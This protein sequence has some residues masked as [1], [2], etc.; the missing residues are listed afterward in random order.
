LQG[1][2]LIHDFSGSTF[3]VSLVEAHGNQISVLHQA[4]V[5][6]LGERDFHHVLLRII[7]EKFQAKTGD[8]FDT[9]DCNFTRLDIESTLSTLI[10][11]PTVMI[12][13]TS[14]KHGPWPI[15]V[16]R[17]EFEAGIA[18]LVTQAE[19]ACEH[20]MRCGKDDPAQHTKP[21]EIRDVFMIGKASRVPALQASVERLFRKKPIIQEP[22]QAIANGAAIYAV[23]K[24]N[25]SLLNALQ[26][27]SLDALKVSLKAPHYFGLAF[28]DWLTG[29]TYNRTIIPKGTSLPVR[30]TFRT[31]ADA[32]GHLPTIRLT[33][34]SI[35]EKNV[36]FVTT[37]WSGNVAPTAPHADIEL[38]FAY[39]ENGT[40]CFS[41]TEVATGNTTIV[42]LRPVSD[43]R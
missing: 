34:S 29:E 13:L 9:V 23:L 25:H 32:R 17:D 27:R 5:Q 36:E 35:E 11:R 41:V 19:M 33:Q 26:L 14:G 12:R 16:S 10:L 40:M 4:S 6:Q 31:Q 39:D 42:D 21:S 28:T 8:E 15:E 18:H 30:R 22:D 1:K 37:I 20:V 7:G 38:I 24:S 2:Y 43:E 3:N